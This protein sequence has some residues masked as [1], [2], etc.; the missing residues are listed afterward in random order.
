MKYSHARLSIQAAS[1]VVIQALFL[2]PFVHAQEVPVPLPEA[3]AVEVAPVVLVDELPSIGS[4]PANPTPDLVTS[5]E[6]PGTD[7]ST[8]EPILAQDAPSEEVVVQQ[9]TDVQEAVTTDM[10]ESTTLPVDVADVPTATEETLTVP[11]EEVLTPEVP[12][13]ESVAEDPVATIEETQQQV[14]I[15]EPSVDETNVS[16]VVEV[17]VTELA[18]EPEFSFELSQESLPTKKRVRTARGIVE[19]EVSTELIPVVDN[20]KG[21]LRIEGECS[22]VSFVVLL[23]KHEDDYARDPASY[24]VNRAYPCEAGR[25]SYSLAS[26]PTT[27]ADGTYYLLVG[28]QGER[29]MWTPVTE[30]RPV[31]INNSTR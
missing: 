1:V 25:F 3:P 8:E 12:V 10:L 4:E 31:T 23:F 14:P 22:N 20:E 5:G 21:E 2:A 27:L 28:E 18:P 11:V 30:L 15:V 9:T 7:S 6:V 19:E 26:L 16:T 13:E 17:P 24:I 29:G